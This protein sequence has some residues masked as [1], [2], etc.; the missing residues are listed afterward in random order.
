MSDPTVMPKLQ[1]ELHTMTI[2]LENKI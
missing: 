1:N 2:K